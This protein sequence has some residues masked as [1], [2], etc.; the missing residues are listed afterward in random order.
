MNHFD[1]ILRENEFETI[2][3]RW[4]DSVLKYFEFE[5]N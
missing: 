5:T 3:N 4:F 1:L 2:K